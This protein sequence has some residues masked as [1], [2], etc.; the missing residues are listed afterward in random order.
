[1]HVKASR[2]RL[3]AHALVLALLAT[4]LVVLP[5]TRAGALHG[6]TANISDAYTGGT[7]ITAGTLCPCDEGDSGTTAFHF[8]VTLEETGLPRLT[9]V[10]VDWTTA[11]GPG[12]N[13]A[14]AADNDYEGADGTL[15]FP[16]GV[17]T[18][19]IDVTVNGDTKVEGSERFDVVLTDVSVDAHL[20]DDT[21]IGVIADDDATGDLPTFSIA[22]ASA[23]EDAGTMTFTVSLTRP[24]GTE[25]TSYEVGVATSDGTATATPLP[26]LVP[27]GDYEAFDGTLTFGSGV[28]TQTF[29]VQINDDNVFEGNETFTATLSGN[30]TGTSI[31]DGTATGTIVEDEPVPALSISDD[32]ELEDDPDENLEFTISLNTATAVPVSVDWTTEDASATL[33]DSDYTAANGTVTFAPGDTSETVEVDQTADANIEADE[34][35]QVVLSNPTGGATI[36]DGTGDGTILN[37]DTGARTVDILDASVAEGDTGTTPLNFTIRLNGYS[38]EAISVQFQTLNVT[39]TDGAAPSGAEQDYQPVTS[40]TVTVPAGTRSVT[41]PVT[42]IGDTRDEGNERFLGR[43]TMASGPG[44]IGDGNATGTILDDDPKIT[45]DDASVAE[46]DEGETP[47]VFTIRTSA[48]PAGDLTVDY[49]TADGAAK[50]GS[51]YAAT[52]GTATIAAGKTSTTFEV[53]VT[54]D[55]TFEGSENFTVTLSN[56]S[57]GA[58]ADALA[59]GT[60]IDDDGALP[61]VNGGADRTLDT[62]EVATFTAT[63]TG[64]TG[65]AA[66]TWDFGDGSPEQTGRSVTHRYTRVGSFTVTVTAADPAGSDTDTVAVTV[67]ET[68]VVTRRSGDD[69]VATSV[70]A[71]R[72]HWST[73]PTVLLATSL[74]FPDAL[75]ASALAGM[76]GAPLVLTPPDR[77]PDTVLDLLDDLSTTRVRIL[78]GTAA[79]SQA[80]EDQLRDA[81]L[82]VSRV[83]GADR[84]A[85]AAAVAGVVRAPARRAVVALGDHPVPSRAWPDA[86]SAGTYAAS[87]VRIPVL[88]TRPDAVPQATMDA[89]SDLRVTNVDLLGGTA[90]ISAAVQQQLEEA[91][92]T[93]TRV[94]GETRYGTSVAVAQR[95]L[96]TLPA[97]S[98]PLVFATGEAFPDGLAAGGLAGRL[99]A[100]VVLVQPGAVPAEVAAFLTGAAHRF[101]DAD[102]LGGTTAIAESVRTE[103]ATRMKD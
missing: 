61:T 33:A 50:A 10:T 64:G 43:I 65:E 18:Q 97:G 102:L 71:A 63:V 35:V 81:D 92:I 45:I 94:A 101:D 72:A 30:D 23:D 51:D 47:M 54:G 77:V 5:A 90:A 89:L 79:V 42:V 25:T 48:A 76:D 41:T 17:S 9:T 24:A 2:G 32:A 74:N 85:T 40:R 6:P 34:V 39:A 62:E 44:T 96:A 37:D 103:L 49:A 57:N 88:L 31:G 55:T 67:V 99:G 69:R 38:T 56:P 1:M 58:L 13:D 60:I 8:D 83:Q 14:R 15:S 36:A 98:I 82:Q 16:P 20:G 28:T 12:V 91:G 46:G 22:D 3:T 52:S 95:V 78:G 59:I 26:I 29:D 21:G 19:T 68:G 11:D 80:V 7:P 66:V 87:G 100:P 73:A 84:F 27:E 86:L 4:L 75:A 53:P 70:A 93:V